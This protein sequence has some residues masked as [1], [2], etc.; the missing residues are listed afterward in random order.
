M[1]FYQDAVRLTNAISYALHDR[2]GQVTGSASNA[3]S[4][5]PHVS[6]SPITTRKLSIEEHQNIV[7]FNS[8]RIS[9]L[10]F[11]K[12]NFDDDS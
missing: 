5:S 4:E 12:R 7:E 1:D 10:S 11:I 3:I 2:S 8:I 9:L 6:F